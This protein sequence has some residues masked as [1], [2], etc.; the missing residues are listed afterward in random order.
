MCEN[1]GRPVAVERLQ[2]RPAARTCIECA[3]GRR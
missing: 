2:A 3:A 1:C